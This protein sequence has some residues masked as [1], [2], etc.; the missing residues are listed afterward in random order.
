MDKGDFL[1]ICEED[2]AELRTIYL[3]KTRQAHKGLS[4]LV[5]FIKTAL[6]AMPD[7]EKSCLLYQKI[8]TPNQLYFKT[9][10]TKSK[11]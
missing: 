1:P 11:V 9:P 8:Q 2:V 4:Q 10:L 7:S 6:S 5:C 3:E